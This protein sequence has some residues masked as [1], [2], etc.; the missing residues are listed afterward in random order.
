MKRRPPRRYDR[1]DFE[2]TITAPNSNNQGQS[3]TTTKNQGVGSLCLRTISWRVAG[4]GSLQYS[5][6]FLLISACSGASPEPTILPLG[7][8]PL[9]Y[10]R[11]VRRIAVTG[12]ASVR[13]FATE[14]SEDG[15]LL[16]VSRKGARL[17]P[18]EVRL[19][20][21]KWVHRDTVGVEFLKVENDDRVLL[22]VFLASRS[23]LPVKE[24]CTQPI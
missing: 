21:V 20:S 24:R 15:T 17:P 16:D 7:V 10:S 1:P 14:D 9:R 13:S 3:L 22:D 6:T 4:R 18:V 23:Q 11:F 8:W 19:A 2:G 5:R 12:E